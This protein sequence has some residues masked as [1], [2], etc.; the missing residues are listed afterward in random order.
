MRLYLLTIFLVSVISVT[1]KAQ[2][3]FTFK[4]NSI[5]SCSDDERFPVEVAIIYDLGFLI[6]MDLNSPDKDKNK[7]IVFNS[8]VKF[9]RYKENIYYSYGSA[10]FTILVDL[11]RKFLTIKKTNKDTCSEYWA[12]SFLD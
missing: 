5:C 10:D 1:S 3:D 8:E 7:G 6:I 11:D 2:G 12:K 4:V 9:N